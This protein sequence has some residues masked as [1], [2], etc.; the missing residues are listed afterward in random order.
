MLPQHQQWQIF[1][2]S[3]LPGVLWTE[4]CIWMSWLFILGPLDKQKAT[5]LHPVGEPVAF[6][7]CALHCEQNIPPRNDAPFWHCLDFNGQVSI[8]LLSTQRRGQ[9]SFRV[10]V[11]LREPLYLWRRCHRFDAA[12]KRGTDLEG[13]K[14]LVIFDLHALHTRCFAS[15]REVRWR[16]DLEQTDRMKNAVESR[17]GSRILFL[18]SRIRLVHTKPDFNE[19]RNKLRFQH[20][21]WKWAFSVRLCTNVIIAKYTP[22]NS[23]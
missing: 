9:I 5:Y 7:V 21:M 14:F 2:R 10:R 6:R 4:Q 16:K 20:C 19:D 17:P 3:S 8:V 22:V 23:P 13:E 15:E 11:T 18:M 1:V 12:Q